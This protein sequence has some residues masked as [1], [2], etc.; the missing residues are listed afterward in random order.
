MLDSFITAER[1]KSTYLI[2]EAVRVDRFFNIPVESKAQSLFPF[3][4]QV[5]E[6][7]P[8]T[9]WIEV[10]GLTSGKR[11]SHSRP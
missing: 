3:N 9:G 6:L 5:Y 2:D 11:R 10:P 8:T 1:K 4:I 7:T